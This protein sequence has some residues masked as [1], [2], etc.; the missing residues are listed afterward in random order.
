[1][2]REWRTLIVLTILILGMPLRGRCIAEEN[3]PAPASQPKIVKAIEIRQNKTVSESVILSKIK[4][5]AGN[6][7]SQN[8]ANEDLKR[9]YA[10]GHFRDI[11]IDLEDYE[12]GLKV[13]FIVTEKEILIEIVISGNRAFRKKR[14]ESLI[15]SRRG[16]VL[17]R[18]Q[19]KEDI[20]EIVKFYEKKGFSRVKI[21]DEIKVDENTNEAKLYIGIEEGK[22]LR[23]KKIDIEG[24]KG[25][26][27]KQLLKVMTTKKDAL[28][29]SGF[30]KKDT[31]EIDIE[32]LIAMYKRAGYMDV[33][34][35]GRLDYDT[36]PGKL[37]ITISITEGR[38]YLVGDIVVQ[39]NKIFPKDDIKEKLNMKSG[40][41]FSQDNIR[42][43]IS[44]IQGY[45]FEKG[46]INAEIKSDTSFN[47]D[48]EKIDITYDILENELI[49]VNK[50]LIKGNVKTKDKVIRR[51]MKIV[52]GEHFDGKKLRRSKENLYNLGF[53]EEV[54]YDTEPTSEADKQNLIVNV[55]EAKTGELSFGAGY[56]TV[57]DFVGFAQVKQNNFD[58]FNFPTFT[59]GGQNL[60]LRGEVGTITK[61][62]ELNFTEPWIFDRPVSFGFDLYNKTISESE[63]LGYGYDEDRQGG[64]LRLG[65]ALGEYTKGN[66]AYRLEKI[67]ISNIPDDASS[68]FKL[69]E[70][71]NTIRSV[72][73]FISKDMRDNIFNPT[74]GWVRTGSVEVAGGP[75]G[76]DKDFVK[77]IGT[78][79]WY[80]PIFSENVLELKL[81]AG[82]VDSFSDSPSVPIYE[83]FYAG[84][85]NTIRGY[86][87]RRI[88]PKDENTGDPIGGESMFVG[89]IEYL[90]PIVKSLKGVVFY[91]VGNVW[92]STEDFGK[93]DLKSSAGVGVRVKT[94]IGPLKLDW[95][96]GLSS[97]ARED[98][99]GRFHFSMSYGF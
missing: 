97:D 62:Y 1:M 58:L 98:D 74:T 80:F 52:P 6:P 42:R 32:K 37:L 9:L 10:T 21:E 25:F 24:N 12:D 43:D 85:A 93:G 29:T 73:L 3:A 60:K 81:R 56:S 11:K 75:F 13:T 57:Q 19:V 20:K 99:T 70:G 78:S 88:G 64:V 86:R 2:V 61:D 59:G 84:G 35:E 89:N 54:T 38:K 22:R 76:G 49:Y 94:P 14:L 23:I 34:A 41:V 8:L 82:I 55:K 40:S 5:K 17:D 44:N 90:F 16:E 51:E 48:T 66:L 28:F 96:Y 87:E 83:R 36:I 50:L 39:G 18:R 71:S 69:E 91:D 26:S 30:F 53:F 45:Y 33:T 4:T 31:F 15:K 47:K 79:A 46:Y 95:G 77:Y 65:K 72:T 68:D 92:P 63:S 27:D 7:F 67:N